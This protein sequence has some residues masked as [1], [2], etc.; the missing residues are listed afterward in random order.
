MRENA[1]GSGK[2]SSASTCHLVIRKQPN[3]DRE[4]AS[5]GVTDIL[6]VLGTKIA[7]SDKRHLFFAHKDF[8]TH[9]KMLRLRQFT[10]N[11]TA[12]TLAMVIFMLR[13]V[14]A[15]SLPF[16]F[17]RQCYCS[18]QHPIFFP[19]SFFFYIST[20]QKLVFVPFT[21]IFLFLSLLCVFLCVSFFSFLETRLFKA[22]YL[23]FNYKFIFLI[24]ARKALQDFC[25]CVCK[26]GFFFLRLFNLPLSSDSCALHSPLATRSS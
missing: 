20:Y 18:S 2:H 26:T 19:Q 21:F 17:S 14:K 10:K 4:Q 15:A 13:H 12:E 24:D 9:S 6:T 25:E 8:Q 7:N 23:T 3:P 1:A 5:N 22:F 11:N 16:S